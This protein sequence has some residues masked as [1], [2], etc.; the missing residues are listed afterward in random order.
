[1]CSLNVLSMRQINLKRFSNE[2]TSF[3]VFAIKMDAAVF[4]VH[5]NKSIFYSNARYF[6]FTHDSWGSFLS[7]EGSVINSKSWLPTPV[8]A[9]HK[10]KKA[11]ART[12]LNEVVIVVRNF[13]H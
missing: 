5:Q 11:L 12:S 2:F 13:I 6:V 7:E 4:D 1:M 9:A 10:P 3:A 8:D